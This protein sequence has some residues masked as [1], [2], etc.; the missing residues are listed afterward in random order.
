LAA[1]LALCIA[2]GS[3]VVA[4]TAASAAPRRADRAAT[5]SGSLPAIGHATDL[6]KEP[7]V[8]ADRSKPPARLLTKNLVVGT[9]ATVA[10]TSTVEVKYVGADYVNGKDFTSAT[11]TDGQATSFALTT[12]VPGFAEGLVGMRVGGRREIVIPPS[13]GYGDKAEGPIKADETL[14]FVVDLESVSS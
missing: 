2:A 12:V 9:G 14:V 5:G 8:H 3:T 7:V 6:A 13:L 11:W 4:A 10:A 1:A